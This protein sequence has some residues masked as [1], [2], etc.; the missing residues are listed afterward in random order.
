MNSNWTGRAPR[1]LKA[2]FGPYTS[3]RIDEPPRVS[4]LDKILSVLL[5]VAIGLALAALLLN[6]MG[7]LLP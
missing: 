6:E 4:R 1:D 7:A 3:S 2:A 5:A